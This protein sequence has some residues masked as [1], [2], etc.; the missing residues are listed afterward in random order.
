M[1][2]L[3]LLS[4]WWNEAFGRWLSKLTEI[5]Q[6][7]GGCSALSF[8]YTFIKSLGMY[9]RQAT[10]W[11]PRAVA[12]QNTVPVLLVLMVPW[13][14]HSLSEWTTKVVRV[15]RCCDWRWSEEA[16]LTRWHLSCGVMTKKPALWRVGGR[17]LR[18]YKTP[19]LNCG[20]L[21]WTLFWV[22]V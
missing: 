14:K 20:A 8:T 22:G 10:W 7:S 21:R 1:L 17:G 16:V 19:I 11:D 3:S 13:G 12:S 4:R 18:G 6:L 2:L 15:M 5:T 9:L